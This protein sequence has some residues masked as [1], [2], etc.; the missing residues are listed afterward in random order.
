MKSFGY[1]LALLAALAWAPTAARAQDFS[2]P[3][4]F[5]K[6]GAIQGT[7]VGAD[8]DQVRTQARANDRLG[9]VAG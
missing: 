1:S 3:D 5:K 6:S 4:L 2:G 7:S 9:K 8:D